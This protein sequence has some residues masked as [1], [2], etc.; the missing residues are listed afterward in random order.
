MRFLSS[1][2]FI[3]LI[4]SILAVLLFAIWSMY[5]E[6]DFTAESLSLVSVGLVELALYPLYFSPLSFSLSYS[7]GLRHLSYV[8]KICLV[9]IAKVVTEEKHD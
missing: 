6:G 7:T 5:S 9:K 8:D 3:E 1:V 2:F 4:P